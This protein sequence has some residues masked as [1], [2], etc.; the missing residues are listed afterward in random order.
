MKTKISVF[1]LLFLVIFKIISYSQVAYNHKIDSIVNLV[2]LQS[3]CKMDRELSGD[4]IAMIGGIPQLIHSRFYDSEGNNKA[5]QYIYEKF[6]SYGY[7]PKYMLNTPSIKNVY[8]IKTGT[9]YPDRKYV[10]G[11]HYDNASGISA[12]LEV[13]RL[14][15]N[16]DLDYTIIF[17]AFDEEERPPY[18]NGSKGFVDSCYI[19]GDTLMGALNMDNIAYDSDNDGK[20][21]FIPDA[22][23]KNLYDD[24]YS[25]NQIYQIGLNI[26][27]SGYTQMPGDHH[28]FWN[29]NY[30][31]VEML[32]HL[33]DFNPYNH[34]IEDKF[35]KL[36]LPY[37]YK[38]VKLVLSTVLSWG[39]D[40]CPNILHYPLKSTT[41]T[42]SRPLSFEVHYPIPIAVGGNSPRLYYKLNNGSYSYLSPISHTGYYYNFILPGYPSGS[43][44]YYYFALQDST[45]T[46]CVTSP[47]GGS[48]FNP[49]GSNP[50]SGT[51][52]YDIFQTTSFTSGSTPKPITDMEYTYDTIRVPVQ[53]VLSDI[54]VT[55]NINHS[56]DGDLLIMLIS[57]NLSLTLCAY[58]GQGG[59][60]FT[61]TIFDDTASLSISQGTPPFTGRFRP[62]GSLISNF[63]GKQIFGDW[64]L[65]IYDIKAGNQGTLLNW[66]IQFK[67]LNQVGIKKTDNFVKDYKLYQNYPNPFNPKTKIHFN[68]KNSGNAKLEVFDITGKLVTMILNE[69]LNMGSYEVYWDASAYPSGVYFYRL[70]TDKYSETKK[71]ILLK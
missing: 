44:I 21:D 5:A 31:A 66:S 43:K 17:V 36:N 26:I 41:D 6:Q 51:Y 45:G 18:A 24:F 40:K 29:K 70:I 60:N 12:I 34:N 20:I 61:G 1:V 16:I 8:A 38:D 10:I 3:I 58:V 2:S 50:P 46:Y 69:K 19:K 37:F 68:L 56:N 63:S 4:T 48:G 52:A 49:P 42:T 62:S 65:K 64:I 47:S 33:Q 55:F 53:G 9:K 23:S 30:K 54:K 7:S 57:S 39:M 32:E 14:I 15:K 11:A 25:C 71:M 67:Y 22:F 13:A 27:L 35:E 28:S 59:Q